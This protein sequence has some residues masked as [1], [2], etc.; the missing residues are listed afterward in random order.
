MKAGSGL[1]AR[2]SSLLKQPF[3]SDFLPKWGQF[4]RKIIVFVAS[5]AMNPAELRDQIN[6]KQAPSVVD[7][8]R[9]SFYLA[10][11]AK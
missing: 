9:K 5:V 6:L 2:S 10:R 11:Q 8:S 4:K 7:E 3:L 1:A